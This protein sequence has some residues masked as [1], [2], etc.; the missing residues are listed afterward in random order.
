MAEQ[1]KEMQEKLRFYLQQVTRAQEE[2]RRRIAQELHDDTTQDL[3][4]L[5]RQLD[6]Y[7][8]TSGSISEEHTTRLEQLRQQIVK[9]IDGVRRFSQDLRPSVLD[10]LGLLPALEW[11]TS[12]LTKHFG[13]I[14]DMNV[15]GSVRR[16]APE[17]EAV[18]F[19]IAQEALRNIW[20]HSEASKASVT[21]QFNTNKTVL[22]VHDDGKGFELP[23]RIEDLTLSG[24]LGL[25]GMQERAQ[26]IGARLTIQSTPGE[27]TTI[28]AEVPI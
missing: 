1:E 6:D 17:T 24:K 2:E 3:V 19:R 27:G 22:A 14:V 16:F 7:I 12:D 23:Q 5:L 28:T 20:K 4:I 11:L 13:V 26:L 18:L 25:T 8:I 10:D 21:V 9:I 15:V